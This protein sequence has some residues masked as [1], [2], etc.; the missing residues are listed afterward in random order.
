MSVQRGQLQLQSG[1]YVEAF[2]AF[3]KL[4]E[5]EWPE[6]LCDPLVGLFLLI[7]DLAINPTRGLPLDIESFDDFILDV[8]VGVR[9]TR[10][11]LAVKELPHLKDVIQEYSR[12]EYL[13]V[14]TELTQLTGYDHPLTG[15]WAV[16][17]WYKDAPGLEKLMEEH[18]TFEFDHS[19]QPIRVF[20]SHFVAFCVDKYEYPEFFCWPGIFMS[21]NGGM[22]DV[23]EIWLRHLS[24]FSDRGDKNG[25]YPR[26]WPNRSETA[27]M[28]TF[29]RFYGTM[30]LYDLTR[31]WV[32]K[33][34]PFVCDYCWISENYSQ[35]HANA[36]AN[37]TMKQV[38]NVTLDDF[39]I[40]Q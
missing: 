5:S 12:K 11:C 17:Q 40:V 31:Q 15:C 38:Y 36:W 37:N 14:S 22:K 23:R 28:Q 26:R 19:N 1:I 8:D 9:F 13:E 27:V 32:L 21:G 18:R 25:V 29:E 33:D 34:G 35:D 7:C 6:D 3:L 20:V 16:K 4:S 39:E 10:L 24:L 2:D 30:A